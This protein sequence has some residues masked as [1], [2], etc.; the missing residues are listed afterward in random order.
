MSGCSLT[1]R[2]TPRARMA[3][4]VG[5]ERDAEGRAQVRAAVTAPPVDG[6][7]NVALV[8]LIAKSLAVPR[9]AVAIVGGQTARTKRLSIAVPPDQLARWL[10]SL[11]E[12]AG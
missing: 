10:D 9:S 7:A 3:R 11:D 1:V 2:L 5:R 4:I 12:V 8:A 6:A